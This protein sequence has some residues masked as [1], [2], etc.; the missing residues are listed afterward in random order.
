MTPGRCI[1]DCWI[2]YALYWF[3]SAF[4][5]KRTV[6][7]QSLWRELAYRAPT[8]LGA[9]LFTPFWGK[10][11][12]PLNL[13]FDN[14][15]ATD[16]AGA[17]LCVSGLAVAIWSR[18]TLAGNWSA[19]VTFKKEHEL[20]ERGPYRFVRHPI[21]TGILMMCAGSALSMGRV[22]PFIG[23]LFL[24][25]GFWIKLR[26]EEELLIR[27]FPIEYPS[28]RTRVKALVPWVL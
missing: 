11:P 3:V 20:V 6:E 16:W 24:T 27:H 9:W 17:G 7:R 18:W 12:F 28:Y 19:T 13:R 1:I 10:W 15:W 26:Q 14:S 25:W 2:A 22:G 4:S 8:I 5:A 21:Y 23:V